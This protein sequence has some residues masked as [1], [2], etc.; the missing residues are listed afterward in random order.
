MIRS[1]PGRRCPRPR[2]NACRLSR[3]AT[4]RAQYAGPTGPEAIEQAGLQLDF[5]LLGGARPARPVGNFRIATKG[6]RIVTAGGLRIGGDGKI[7]ADGQGS[8]VYLAP[9]VTLKD[10]AIQINGANCRV[11]IGP[12][13]RMKQVILK[14]SGDD[15]LVAMGAKTTWESG[16]CI[17]TAGQRV[18][19]GN[20]CMFSNDVVM[21]TFDGHGIWETASGK[22]LNPP[23]T[24][25]SRI[26]SGSAT[27]FASTRGRGSRRGRWSA[28]GRSFRATSTATASMPVCPPRSSRRGSIGPAH[29]L[30]TTAKRCIGR[31]CH[32]EAR[33][34]RAST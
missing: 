10:T 33:R 26:T 20:D 15:C 25:R 4:R 21:R 29:G 34:L 8:L 16:A 7:T 23:A 22:N 3:L 5:H 28:S 27:G 6:S 9:D 1:R 24:S 11:F 30:R 17:C 32:R 13:V 18:L 19:V 14:L 2:A 31:P 12:G